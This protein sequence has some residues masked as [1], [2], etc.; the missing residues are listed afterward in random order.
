MR[1]PTVLALVTISVLTVAPISWAQKYDP[2]Q[3]MPRRELQLTAAERLVILNALNNRGQVNP[4]QANLPFFIS[5]KNQLSEGSPLY[6]SQCAA[7]NGLLLTAQDIAAA[8]LA[9]KV[10][11]QCAQ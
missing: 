9:K 2:T 11:Q 4:D 10:Q 8:E 1:F 7:I 5:I 6:V 3:H